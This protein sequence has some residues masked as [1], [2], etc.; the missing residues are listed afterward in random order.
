PLFP[1]TTLFRSAMIVICIAFVP[2]FKR[3][4]V[5]T[6]YEYLENRFNGKTRSLTSF[7]FLLQRGLS[8]GISVFAPSIILSSLFNWNIY[9]T[10]I[11][12]GG[13]L[14]IYT[15]S[16][17]A[18]AVV[19]T[20]KLQLIIIFTGM[21]LSTYMVV[22]MLPQNVGFTDALHI[23]GELGKLNVITSGFTEQG[24]NWSDRYNIFSGI[25]G[26]FFLAL[27]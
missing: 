25:I 17:G 6:A 7:L 18:R 19:H 10:N 13:L 9:W 20:Q 3:L 22:S 27:S 2:I 5:Y 15:M 1:Y 11:F 24:Y 8:T 12:M 14:I 16:G 21:F 23:S 4:N 26:G